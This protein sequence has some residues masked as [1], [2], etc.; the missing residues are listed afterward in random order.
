MGLHTFYCHLTKKPLVDPVLTCDGWTFERSVITAW[1]TTHDT[2]PITQEKFANKKLVPNVA[3]KSLIDA[4]SEDAAISALLCPI[5]QSVMKKVA[6]TQLGHSYDETN[7]KKWL[8]TSSINPSSGEKLEDKTLI[9]N[10]ALQAVVDEYHKKRGAVKKAIEADDIDEVWR[11]TANN[12][13]LL[14]KL[15][16]EEHNALHWAAMHGSIKVAT[17]LQK[18]YPDFIK[19][20]AFD[21]ST[22]LHCAADHDQE[23]MVSFLLAQG[24]DI[25]AINNTGQTPIH[26]A[27]AAGSVGSTQLMLDRRPDLL[28]AKNRQDET[29]LLCAAQSRKVDLVNILISRG[30]DQEA[31]NAE[32]YSFLHL[33]SKSGSDVFVAQCLTLYFKMQALLNVKTKKGNQLAI[34]LAAARGDAA[35]VATLLRFGADPSLSNDEEQNALHLA[36]AS[37]KRNKALV[38]LLLAHN[39]DLA[40]TKDKKGDTPLHLVATIVKAENEEAQQVQT[41]ESLAIA[42]ELL[43]CGADIDA[44]NSAKETPA[45]ASV[46][47]LNFDI[48]KFLQERGANLEIANEHG[49]TPIQLLTALLIRFGVATTENETTQTSSLL[50]R[51]GFTFAA[52]GGVLTVIS[53]AMY[54][55]GL[56]LVLI[57]IVFPTT[58]IMAGLIV[59][60]IGAG[61]FVAGMAGVIV[62]GSLALVGAICLFTDW[63][64]NKV[65]ASQN[66]ETPAPLATA[67][68]NE[69]AAVSEQHA[70]AT[71][72]PEH[73][74]GPTSISSALLRGAL[75]PL[76]AIASAPATTTVIPAPPVIYPIHT[77]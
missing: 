16:D 38:K 42:Q 71:P 35:M 43:D 32:G 12:Q 6:T 7:I 26:S 28:E 37:S 68:H 23:V 48:L 73:H 67:L 3:L 9:G 19:A 69:N 40:K 57:T 45:Y 29:P 21:D 13:H 22:P 20:K 8:E 34:G 54:T 72:G 64:I 10:W 4:T 18:K 49:V 31:V 46:K 27:A 66:P 53:T 58:W 61:L 17:A 76:A 36:V 75:P 56:I 2:N 50:S 14:E 47:H 51:V 59:G 39:K 30:A 25:S 74:P 60:S 33:A 62:S 77:F 44:Q 15:D 63:I 70:P 11:L 5:D 24:A 1:L 65:N 41:T 52:V 55:L